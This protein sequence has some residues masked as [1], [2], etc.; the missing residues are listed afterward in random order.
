MKAPRQSYTR[1]ALWGFFVFGFTAL[2]LTLIRLGWISDI[3][4]RWETWQVDRLDSEAELVIARFR[5][6][7]QRLYLSASRVRADEELLRCITA[8]DRKEAARAF[9]KLG[10]YQPNHETSIA[11]FDPRGTLI[12]WSGRGIEVRNADGGQ[13]LTKDSSLAIV[14]RD[15]HTY[16]SAALLAANSAL[17]IV[18]SEPFEINYPISNR[19]VSPV[20]FTGDISRII[21]RQVRLVMPSEEPNQ[22]VDQYRRVPL[23]DPRGRVLATVFIPFPTPE[24]AQQL[25]SDTL[26]PWVRSAA[27]LGV[28]CFGLFLI[29]RAAGARSRWAL[30]VTGSAVLVFMRYAWLYFDFPGGVIGGGVFDPANYGATF[31]G[32]LT[33]SAGE[34]L[35]SIVFVFALMSLVYGEV[36]QYVERVNSSK[37]SRLQWP[38]IIVV[39]FTLLV[40]ILAAMRMYGAAIRSFHFDST[41]W[42]NDPTELVPSLVTAVMQLNALLLT[43]G[44]LL[45]TVFA[46][47]YCRN[48]AGRLGDGNEQIRWLIVSLLFILAF[49]GFALLDRHPQFY[50]TFPFI[51]YGSA[52]AFIV[53]SRILK[54]V[55]MSAGTSASLSIGILLFV[56]FIGH[57]V[58]F[59]FQS[60]RKEEQD[61][62]LMAKRLIRPADNWLSFIV[63]DGLRIIHGEFDKLNVRE[64]DLV[65]VTPPDALSLWAKTLLSREGY[66]SGVFLYNAQGELENKFTV[67]LTSYEETE[68]LKRLYDYDEEVLQVVERRTATSTIKYYGIWGTIRNAQGQLDAIVSVMLAASPRG[69]FRGDISQPLVQVDETEWF[70]KHRNIVVTEYQNGVSAATSADQLSVGMHLDPDVIHGMLTNSDRRFRMAST[71][72]GKTYNTLF[73]ED[74]TTEGRII[75]VSLE[76]P[77]LRW[78]VSTLAKLFLIYVAVGAV[79]NGTLLWRRRGVRGSKAFGFRTKLI[80]ALAV[81]SVVPL[82]LVAY[83]NNEFAVER[84]E[85]NLQRELTQ[86]LELGHRRILST[87][88]SELDF[89]EGVTDDYCDIVASELGVDLSIYRRTHLQA[90]SRPELYSSGILDSLLPADAFA[91]LFVLGRTR[92]IGKDEIGQ[93]PYAVGYQTIEINGRTLGVLA[94]PTLSRQSDLEAELVERNVFVLSIY[95]VILVLVIG[96]SIVIAYTLSGPIRDLTRAARAV[97]EGNLDVQVSPQSRDEIGELVDAFNDMTREIKESRMEIAKAEREMAWKEMAKQV[98]HEIRNPLTPMKLSIQHL[99]QAFRDKASNLDEIIQTVSQTVMDQI[100]SLTRIAGE[101]SQFARMPQRTY[102]RVH[103]NQLLQ[104]TLDLFREVKEIEFDSKFA[105]NDPELVADRDELRR[106]FVNI[107]RNAIQAMEGGGRISVSSDA[108]DGTCIIRISDSGP[109]IPD[110]LLARVFEPNFSTKSEGM[111]LG[112]AISKKVIEDLNGSIWINSKVGF[113]TTVEITLPVKPQTRS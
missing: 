107:V 48:L 62:E 19:F 98:A 7:A 41:I 25:I 12:A 60:H 11:V 36:A 101:F 63:S 77:S 13:F 46:L 50:P 6:H 111:G 42:Y 75:A 22:L 65:G 93:S 16:L 51:I 112:L 76:E 14:R 37:Q 39:I 100:D 61:G 33:T 3:E 99:R 66:N 104:E 91:N 40:A 58:E 27:G 92:Y 82:F 105:D 95:I 84:L 26:S 89:R 73:L 21:G 103:L 71:I 54:S 94:M 80:A 45:I 108:G 30:P 43:L 4:S 57:A 109:G 47:R 97:G 56:T 68:F 15:L 10:S 38:W 53:F 102:E 81:L 59:D 90:S 9:E 20:S 31:A 52:V 72:S 113:G 55:R 24:F 64:G 2:T 8:V 88:S 44:L 28:L 35:I 79:W 34:T 110:L 18:S 87:I 67:G 70:G 83:Y 96:T 85:S 29:S 17:W 86:N 69:L 1:P 32:G 78:H 49:G 106:V 74:H 23:T 5:S